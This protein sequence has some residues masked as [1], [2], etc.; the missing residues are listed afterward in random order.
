M[1]DR[2]VTIATFLFPFQA[3]MEK[4]HLESEGIE[5]VIPGNS[6]TNSVDPSGIAAV[7]LQVREEDAE[8][9]M[10]VLN[11]TGE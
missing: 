4:L 3:E 9:A 10:M 6:V 2:F 7:R 8:R 5:A 11:E 1:S